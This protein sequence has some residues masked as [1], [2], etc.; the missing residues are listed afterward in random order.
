[1]GFTSTLPKVIWL[2]YLGNKHNINVNIT[3][4]KWIG[5][6]IVFCITQYGL[7]GW[8]NENQKALMMMANSQNAKKLRIVVNH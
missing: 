3:V 1:M 7:D 6:V 4:I 2:H 5:C 8:S